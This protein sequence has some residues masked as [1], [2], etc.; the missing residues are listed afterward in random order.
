MATL[1]R[2]AVLTL[3]R[4][5]DAAERR[6]NDAGVKRGVVNTLR[7]KHGSGAKR[8][9]VDTTRRSAAKAESRRVGSSQARFA[10]EAA[11]RA[12]SPPEERR[13]QRPL[14][15]LEGQLHLVQHAG[16]LEFGGVQLGGESA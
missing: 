5:H 13:R 4:R 8:A 3:P 9:V 1:R 16:R 2:I 7:R 12:A 15:G 14:S 10:A 6:R 11:R